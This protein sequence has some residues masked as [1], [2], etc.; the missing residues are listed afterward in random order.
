MSESCHGAPHGGL[1]HDCAA[2]LCE[3][4]CDEAERWFY[5]GTPPPEPV[6]TAHTSLAA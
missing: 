6:P 1:C 3:A 5:G 4:V 2:L